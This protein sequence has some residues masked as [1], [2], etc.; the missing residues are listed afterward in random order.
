MSGSKKNQ[1]VLDEWTQ[2]SF[3]EKKKGVK[4]INSAIKRAIAEVC[5]ATS[6][7]WPIIPE[8]TS[9]AL[10]SE[11][12]VTVTATAPATWAVAKAVA[13]WTAVAIANACERPD[14]N[15]PTVEILPKFKSGKTINKPEVLEVRGSD[16]YLWGEKFA[17]CKDNESW[18]G[19]IL[20]SINGT[21]VY[22]WVIVDKSCNIWVTAKDNAEKPNK[23]DTKILEVTYENNEKPKCSFNKEK[24]DVVKW[25][26]VTRNGKN[27]LVW[28]EKIFV[29]DS[30]D[31]SF[32]M[33]I[34]KEGTSYQ[35]ITDK[36]PFT[37]DEDGKRY[38]KCILT[39]DNNKQSDERITEL[40][41]DDNN[42]APEITPEYT[43]VV[44][45]IWWVTATM[46]D[47]KLFFWDVAMF[48]GTDD[49]T[50]NLDMIF[51]I[52][53]WVWKEIESWGFV[54][55]ENGKTCKW[56]LTVID[57]EEKSQSEEFSITSQSIDLKNMN[58]LGMQVGVPVDLLEWMEKPSELEIVKIEIEVGGERFEVNAK[59]YHNYVPNKSWECTIYIAEKWPFGNIYNDKVETSIRA[60]EYEAPI[61]N[62]ANVM[63]KYPR[64]NNLQQSTR[65]FIYPH[66]LAS[67]LACNW[68]KQDNRVHIIMWEAPDAPGVENIWQ[69]N[70][71]SSHAYSWYY[72]MR[73]MAPDATI[74]WCNDYYDN[75]EKY[76]DQ[77]PDKY[78]L[79]SCAFMGIWWSS[80]QE[81]QDCPEVP[82]LRRILKKKNVIVA[83]AGGNHA[84]NR[85]VYNESVKDWNR[86]EWWSINTEW[87]NNKI[88]V[89]WYG[90]R[91]PYNYF[92]PDPQ[93]YWWLN[94]ALPVWYDIEKWNIL[95]PMTSLIY[96]DNTEDPRTTCSFAT[97][98]A[99]AIIWNAIDIVLSNPDHSGI[100]AEDAMTII[101]NNYLIQKKFKYKDETTNWELVDGGDW[102]FIDMQNLINNE[103]LQENKM[104]KM[105]FNAD[106]VELPYEEW[107]ACIGKWLQFKY[108]WEIYNATKDNQSILDEA[109]KSWGVKR[110][111][112]NKLREEQWWD[113]VD[114]YVYGV[115]K[116][117][118]RIPD[119]ELHVVRDL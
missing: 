11:T 110:Y 72:R 31:Y 9:S 95:M 55:L 8:V 117:W 105:Q 100:T 35:N 93:K 83:F 18:I 86:Y 28:W 36:V 59:D 30:D 48:K 39:N 115:D 43:G 2:E 87:L 89:K 71:Y 107:V 3:S 1:P 5:M 82:A 32:S 114:F 38:L 77:H 17:V 14:N 68:A 88:T 44:N 46:K 74:K 6:L 56:K 49:N 75:L 19:E 98:V 10:M 103:L 116:D 118:H 94:N 24:I 119:V 7:S 60:P 25:D 90:M 92:S 69:F 57:S 13:L 85:K 79:I 78:F 45:V 15:K 109:L 73:A 54:K 70:D 16:V 29:W 52:E 42:K 102:Y 97:A 21:N 26:K 67:Y 106:V 80:W 27:I 41:V 22:S 65:D 12:A 112:S 37:L 62:L 63:E 64:F 47:N 96:T 23:S 40:N 108:N 113:S 111:Y 33:E 20:L 84:T 50:K 4:N 61:I 91:E 101:R 51:E 66:I 34:C 81:L 58:N 104:K 53:D 76:I 99:I